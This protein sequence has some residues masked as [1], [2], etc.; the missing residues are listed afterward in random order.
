MILVL[1]AGI[2]VLGLVST[3][4]RAARTAVRAAAVFEWV[5]APQRRA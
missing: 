3:G 5:D 4:R 1:G 2:V